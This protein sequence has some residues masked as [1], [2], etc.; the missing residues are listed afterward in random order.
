MASPES[1]TSTSAVSSSCQCGR[2]GEV[3]NACRLESRPASRDPQFHTVLC[4]YYLERASTALYNSPDGKE[5]ESRR[6]SEESLY[7]LWENVDLD[8][9]SSPFRVLPQ[10]ALTDEILRKIRGRPP[11]NETYE[12]MMERLREK[13]KD[14]PFCGP[15]PYPSISPPSSFTSY[16]TEAPDVHDS[17]SPESLLVDQRS[18]GF[19]PDHEPTK[20]LG[21]SS[22]ASMDLGEPFK[23]PGASMKERMHS[24]ET[25]VEDQYAT[26]F[27]S[28]DHDSPLET[29]HGPHNAGS[30]AS[31]SSNK[32]C[33]EISS[34]LTSL[35]SSQIA[36]TVGIGN[37][38]LP[39]M[40]ARTDTCPPELHWYDHSRTLRQSALSQTSKVTFF[41]LG[42]SGKRVIPR[43]LSNT[44]ELHR[45]VGNDKEIVS[46][47]SRNRISTARQSRMPLEPA[48]KQTHTTL[49]RKRDAQ[50]AFPSDLGSAFT[51]PAPAPELRPGKRICYKT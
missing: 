40:C 38:S 1:Q 32:L 31:H 48:N 21:S 37:L 2:C 43:P 24:R 20:A 14:D 26:S 39:S 25:I 10:W 4:G 45:R 7:N 19:K 51:D 28:D 11:A 49:K 16:G 8:L 23:A 22:V 34:P 3:I 18:G 50:N 42:Y 13:F 33:N 36:D 12:Q 15:G 6:R 17:K 47:G 29:N 44:Q 9:E 35:P 41:E 30:H 46:D 5:N 27:P